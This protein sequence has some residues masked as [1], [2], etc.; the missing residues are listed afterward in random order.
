MA[1]ANKKRNAKKSLSGTRNPVPIITEKK[2]KKNRTLL[3]IVC[4]FL[5]VVLCLSGTLLSVTLI[6]NA[7]YVASYSGYGMDEGVARY[8]ASAY[9]TDYIASLPLS[10]RDSADDPEFWNTVPDGGTISYGEDLQRGYENYIRRILVANA[11]YSSADSFDD[12]VERA[13]SFSLTDPSIGGS[14]NTLNEKTAPYGF[15]YDDLLSAGELYYRYVNACSSIYGKYGEYIS[16][17]GC[18]EYLKT[19]SYVKMIFIKSDDI[20]AKAEV[21]DAVASLRASIAEGAD[22]ASEE[23]FDGFMKHNS[24]H[25]KDGVDGE[26]Y[27]GVNSDFTVK[28]AKTDDKMHDIVERALTMQIG[29]AAEMPYPNGVCFIYKCTP[30]DSH[31]TNSSYDLYF[32]DFYTDAADYLYKSEVN[33]RIDDVKFK[34]SFYAIDVAATPKNIFY[35]VKFD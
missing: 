25:F 29:E 34:D 24:I 12:E 5:G 30:D 16:V 4:I 14:I 9:K 20:S 26:Y 28:F 8:F 32:E 7:R 23:Q 21:A 17:A 10:V 11:L 27:F 1:Q 33:A 18:S 31:Y 13:V 6:R 3:I 19:Y 22:M 35:L 2:P 15:D